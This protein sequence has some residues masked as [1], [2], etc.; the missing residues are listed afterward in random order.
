MLLGRGKTTEGFFYEYVETYIFAS[1]RKTK[2]AVQCYRAPLQVELA[3][4]W[5]KRHALPRYAS[6]FFEA[7]AKHLKEIFPSDRGS[8]ILDRM[9]QTK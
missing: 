1:D 6:G 2:R 5:E 3:V 7:F 8:Q 4:I 9:R